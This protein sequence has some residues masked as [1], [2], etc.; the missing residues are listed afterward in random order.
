VPGQ[1]EEPVIVR[2]RLIAEAP[3]PEERD[4]RPTEF[5]LQ[6]KKQAVHAGREQ[7]DGAVHFECEAQARR[8]PLTGEAR[9]SGAWVHGTAAEPFVYLS[10]KYA[11]DPPQWIRRQKIRLDAITWKQIEEARRS[12]GLLQ[13]TVPSIL[14]RT[15][16]V[17]VEWSPVNG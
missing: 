7:P 1:F 14:V 12:N 17:P 8:N 5:G 15:A 2:L 9:F 6:D 16:T 10:W 11:E 3:P 13:A 4:G